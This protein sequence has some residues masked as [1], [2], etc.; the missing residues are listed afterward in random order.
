VKLVPYD[1]I[2]KY[3][4]YS[5][6]LMALASELIYLLHIQNRQLIEKDK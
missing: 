6:K 3:V 1:T 4:Y 5:N 2:V